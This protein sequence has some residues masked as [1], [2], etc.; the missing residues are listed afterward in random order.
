MKLNGAALSILVAMC[1]AVSSPPS[2]AGSGQGTVSSVLVGRLGYQVYVQLTNASFTGFAC[3]NPNPSSWQWAFSTQTQ[4]GRDMLATVLAAKA[5]GVTLYVVGTNTCS[6][7][8]AL[9]DVA[10]VITG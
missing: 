10:Y 6:Q 7:D 3:G 9:E 2:I 8:P 4:S 5:T 1:M